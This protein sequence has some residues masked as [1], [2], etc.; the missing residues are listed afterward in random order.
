MGRTGATCIACSTAVDLKITSAQKDAA[1]G[2]GQQLMAIVAEGH[3]DAV[4]LAPTVG[5]HD[6]ASE[7]RAP[8]DIPSAS[9][10]P[11]A[12]S[13]RV[14]AYGM[15]RWSDLFT[16]RQLTALTTFSD[17]VMEARERVLAD[18]LAAGLPEGDRL[19]AGG[20]GAAAYADA[21]AT[22]LGL[23]VSRNDGL[24][25]ISLCDGESRT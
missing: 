8:D 21:V 20:T 2:S 19:E 23:G 4:Y 5:Q 15:N 17:L 13:F 3:R 7:C 11:Q 14:Q 10:P 6:A 1:A 9:I 18:A 22:Y 25:S 16:P 12:P 24:S